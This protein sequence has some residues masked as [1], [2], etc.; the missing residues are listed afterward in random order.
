MDSSF[1][2]F[3]GVSSSGPAKAVARAVCRPMPPPTRSG[4][5]AAFLRSV[6]TSA[7]LSPDSYREKPL[8]RRLPSCFRFL[9]VQTVAEAH[10]AVE[11]DPSLIGGLLDVLLLGVTDF[12]R[13]R[14]VYRHLKEAVVPVLLGQEQP[15]RAWSAACSDGRE[16]YSFAMLLKDADLLSG[17]HL[18]GTDCRESAIAAAACG[19]YGLSA[20]PEAGHEWRSHFNVDLRSAWPAAE[21]HTA[22]H[23]RRAD[24]LQAAEPGPWD[25]VLWRN[26]AIYLEP[27][28]AESVWEAIHRELRPG[29]FLVTGKA[30]NPPRFLKLARIGPCLYRKEGGR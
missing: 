11:A 2:H 29:G 3:Q 4:D 24:L 16:L 10:R 17:A 7:G 23:W 30:D 27:A 20:L 12:C 13:D 15:V 8:L 25:I 22:P 1:L 6:L 28:A 5:E 21:I 19:R 26:M 14:D 9:R 18:L